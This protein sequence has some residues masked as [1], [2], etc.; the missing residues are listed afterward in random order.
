M[1]IYMIVVPDPTAVTVTDL[2]LLHRVFTQNTEKI[3]PTFQNKEASQKFSKL[4]EKLGSYQSKISFSF[5]TAND[6]SIYIHL[7]T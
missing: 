7:V 2:H 3:L 6:R 4:L 5:L 1:L